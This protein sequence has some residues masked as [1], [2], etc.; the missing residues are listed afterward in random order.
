LEAL[1]FHLC[2][3]QYYYGIYAHS[4][5]EGKRRIG[6]EPH[7]NA[8]DSCTCAS[9]AITAAEQLRACNFF[10]LIEKLGLK[11]TLLEDI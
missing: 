7:Y 6:Y 5:S 2:S 9:I 8:H 11:V 3:R 10:E 4:G 1:F